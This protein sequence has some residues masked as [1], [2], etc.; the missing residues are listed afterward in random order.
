MVEDGSGIHVE[1][2]ENVSANQIDNMSE[3]N[4]KGN[5]ILMKLLI[6]YFFTNI[7]YIKFRGRKS[8]FEEETFTSKQTEIFPN[9]SDFI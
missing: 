3:I 9:I 7:M 4:V 5:L 8:V 2:Q 1:M 6:N